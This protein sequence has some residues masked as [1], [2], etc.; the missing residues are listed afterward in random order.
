MRHTYRVFQCFCLLAVGVLVG[1]WTGT[2]DTVSAQVSSKKGAREILI[3]SVPIHLGDLE[4]ST[5]NAL[6][7]L[8][9]VS[10]TAQVKYPTG[11]QAQV[12][13]VQTKQPPSILGNVTIHQGKVV[14]G[15]RTW[16]V[17]GDASEDFV[18]FFQRLYGAFESASAETHTGTLL[19]RT[20]RNPD[21]VHMM[22]MLDFD[23]R[24]ATMVLDQVAGKPGKAFNLI[25]VEENLNSLTSSV[26][27]SL[28]K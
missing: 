8:Y 7:K 11:G 26:V 9:E 22:I 12:F 10:D 3:G 21:G 20:F 14:D 2:T 23:G 17:I 4:E 15:T 13:V 18:S 27:P 1:R 5:L 19:C 28:V 16:A 6:R 25:K 24:E